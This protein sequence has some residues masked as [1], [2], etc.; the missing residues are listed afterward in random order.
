MSSSSHNTSF[1]L[2]S[3]YISIID[4][5]NS[6]ST[7]RICYFISRTCTIGWTRPCY[8]YTDFVSINCSCKISRRSTWP[9]SSFCDNRTYFSIK[10]SIKKW[11]ICCCLWC[12]ISRC[13]SSTCSP[14]KTI[15]RIICIERI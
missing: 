4:T 12:I 13:R 10:I 8:V 11:V 5:I 2:Y 9:R 6:Q 7:Y 1:C 3:H 15:N 14:S